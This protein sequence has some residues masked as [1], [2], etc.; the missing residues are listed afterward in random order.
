M[1]ILV[2]NRNQFVT[3]AKKRKKNQERKKN[4]QT[5]DERRKIYFFYKILALQAEN[6]VIDS[7]DLL[8]RVVVFY[9]YIYPVNYRTYASLSI[10]VFGIFDSHLFFLSRF[11]FCVFLCS[12]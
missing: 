4:T 10:L 8:S 1:R 11:F 12:F 9:M 2:N 7:A 3:Q 5:N 6:R